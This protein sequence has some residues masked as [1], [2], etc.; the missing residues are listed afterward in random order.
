MDAATTKKIK[1][2]GDKRRG[3]I[4]FLDAIE[5]EPKGKEGYWSSIKKA[6][7]FYTKYYP[8][9]MEGT[10][11]QVKEAKDAA[12]N[13]FAS[14]KS[15]DFRYLVIYPPGFGKWM[16]II[17]VM[18]EYNPDYLLIDREFAKRFP[19]FKVPDVI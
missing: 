5:G 9:L 12:S 11:R 15:K 1:E 4:G 14:N 2:F 7:D 8:W 10:L 6:L 3:A 17:A 19:Q 16:T 13:K 18:K